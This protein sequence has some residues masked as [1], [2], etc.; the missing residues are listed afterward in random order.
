FIIQT[1][2]RKRSSPE[3]HW[4]RFSAERH[5]KRFSAER[6]WKRFSAER[7]WKRFS[8]ERHWMHFAAERRL[9]LAVCFSAAGVDRTLEGLARSANSHPWL[10]SFPWARRRHYAGS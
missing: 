4:K 8:A 7:H 3:R 9:N 6:H 1:R 10:F 5:W 2:H